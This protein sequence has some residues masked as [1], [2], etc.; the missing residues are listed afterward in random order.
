MRMVLGAQ[1]LSV[2]NLLVG[3]GMVAL[4]LG[5]LGGLLAAFLLR[6]WISMLIYRGPAVDSFV[7]L[8]IAVVLITLGALAS[9]IPTMRL[10]RMNLAVVLRN[11]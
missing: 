5:V 1:R 8:L 2:I 4:G 7:F 6:R 3:R 10:T 11:Q 9:L